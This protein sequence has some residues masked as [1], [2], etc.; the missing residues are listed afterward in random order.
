MLLGG[1][2]PSVG[3]PPAVAPTLA[4]AQSP[5][6][7]ASSADGREAEPEFEAEP[8][9]AIRLAAV[10]EGVVFMRT[11]QECE[12]WQ[13]VDGGTRI[14]SIPDGARAMQ[15]SF[16][17]DLRDGRAVVLHDPQA[18]SRGVKIPVECP[19]EP[20]TTEV[21]FV[22]EADCMAV[23]RGIEI[24]GG[25][26]DGLMG[27]D[28]RTA[29]LERVEAGRLAL[30]EAARDDASAKTAMFTKA[31]RRSRVIYW[32]QTEDDG[33]TSCEKWVW[34]RDGKSEDYGK[35][36]F[37]PP[38]GGTVF[39]G[40]YA[41]FDEWG[42][43]AAKVNLLGPHSPGGPSYMHWDVRALHEVTDRFAVVGDE[44]WFF[45]AAACKRGS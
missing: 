12:A 41:S 16:G 26:P 15:M 40:I 3:E 7:E 29:L 17:V 24:R 32:R 37:R 39:D 35:I 30:R 5:A 20:A 44:R 42:F 9:P 2:H 8:E 34:R 14:E 28:Q 23:E 45:S 19:D 22:E 4:V 43:P 13:F 27:V 38:G 21:L 33:T 31:L 18:E 6:A 11:G 25:C 1:C 36:V 10:H